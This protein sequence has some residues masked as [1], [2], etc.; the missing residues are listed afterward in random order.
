MI[1]ALQVKVGELQFEAKFNRAALLMS[2]ILFAEWIW[3]RFF[4]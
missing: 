3:R 2:S 1:A 4:S